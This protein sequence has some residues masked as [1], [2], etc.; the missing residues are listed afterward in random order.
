MKSSFTSYYESYLESDRKRKQYKKR[1]AARPVP[2][3]KI[4][5]DESDF[6]RTIS[7]TSDGRVFY[8]DHVQLGVIRRG[9]FVS[10]RWAYKVVS[11]AG[12]RAVKRY[13]S[14]N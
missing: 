5:I 3:C 13:L 4:E 9:R 7:V 14:L 8:L 12:V 2:V 6:N 1:R 10:E 11:M